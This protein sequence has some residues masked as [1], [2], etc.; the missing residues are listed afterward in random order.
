MRRQNS[1]AAAS[2]EAA[3]IGGLQPPGGFRAG[4]ASGASSATFLPHTLPSPPRLRQ[5]AG[6]PLSPKAGSSVPRRRPRLPLPAHGYLTFGREINHTPKRRSAEPQRFPLRSREVELVSRPS[7]AM[8]RS[9]RGL[10]HSPLKAGTRVRIPY[11]LPFQKQNRHDGGARC[12]LRAGA[13]GENRAL[14]R[15]DARARL[16]P[17]HELQDDAKRSVPLPRKTRRG[18]RHVGENVEPCCNGAAGIV[19]HP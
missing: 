7:F 17:L 13:R 16:R 3:R 18:P 6:G 15:N 19:V 9:S 2:G 5:R 11:A 14:H 4:N 1:S 8:A 12:R 10:G